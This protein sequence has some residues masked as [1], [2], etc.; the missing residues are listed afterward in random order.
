MNDGDDAPL[1]VEQGNPGRSSIPL[2]TGAQRRGQGDG[3]AGD[4]KDKGPPEAD[5]FEEWVEWKMWKAKQE[6][7]I[8]PTPS[9]PTTSNAIGKKP[10]RMKELDLLQASLRP[11][12]K[13]VLAG[14]PTGWVAME[15]I[16]REFDEEKL[17]NCKEDLD[18][19]LVFVSD[20]VLDYATTFL[21]KQ[22]S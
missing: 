11:K 12:T 10:A 14:L 1:D 17:D 13:Y 20:V 5:S 21:T 8:K 6:A 19:L 15:T 22:P 7:G 9:V 16:M 18:T 2:V 4:A 3:E